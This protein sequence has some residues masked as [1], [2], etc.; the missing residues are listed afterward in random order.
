M[1][2]KVCLHVTSM[3]PRQSKSPAKFNIV[4]IVTVPLMQKLQRYRNGTFTLRANISLL[5]FNIIT[6]TAVH[7]SSFGTSMF[8]SNCNTDKN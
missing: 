4:S 2:V 5:S 3:C 1:P 8:S 6:S 7:P